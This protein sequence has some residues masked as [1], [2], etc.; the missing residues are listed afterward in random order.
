MT[1]AG[2]PL[3]F[4]GAVTEPASVK[5]RQF[6]DIPDLMTRT[7]PPIDYIVPSLGIAANTVGLWTGGDGEG[8]TYLAQSMALAVARGESFLGMRC[9]QRPVLYLDLE[10]PAFM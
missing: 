1:A 8:K 2:V 6:A 10:N 7:F 5:I 9:R 4:D 3:S